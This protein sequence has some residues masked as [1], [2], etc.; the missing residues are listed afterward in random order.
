MN[1]YLFCNW[2]G[3]YFHGSFINNN[4]AFTAF[5]NHQS[6][7]YWDNE[8]KCIKHLIP[9]NAG[10]YARLPL[11]KDDIIEDVFSDSKFILCFE[12]D[13]LNGYLDCNEVLGLY[14]SGN[15][16][17]VQKIYRTR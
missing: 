1:N 16:N 2:H 13:S 11:N 10:V 5:C 14:L 15:I 12:G 9:Q 7:A 6:A 8:G 3:T 17:A 4:S